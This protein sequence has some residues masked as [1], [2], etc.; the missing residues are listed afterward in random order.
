V[1]PRRQHHARVSP[2]CHITP[3]FFFIIPCFFVFVN[4]NQKIQRIFP[5]IMCVLDAPPLYNRS[6]DRKGA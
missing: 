2:E 3:L 4:K 1:P 5:M 6:K